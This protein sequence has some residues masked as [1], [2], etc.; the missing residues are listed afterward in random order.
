MQKIGYVRISSGTQNKAT[1]IEELKR[2][3]VVEIR[4]E[5]ITG[6]AKNKTVL[7][8]L[9]DE[10]QYGD[11]I[12]V[13]RLD[14]LGRN[15]SQLLLLVEQLADKGV[16]LIILDMHIDTGTRTGKLFLTIMAGISEME[17][18][19][20]KEKQRAGVELAKQSGKYKG[21]MKRYTDNNPRL[22][23]ALK[24]YTEGQKTVKE[25]AN[26]LSIGEATIYRELK[27]RAIVRQTTKRM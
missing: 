20:I 13:T 1:Q 4:E 3:G 8:T 17:R 2:N 12:V 24:W 19:L 5:T 23:Q 11:S 26:I 9:I 15:A 21:R 7:E 14:R 6:V 22:V 25:I 16:N 27:S 10:L 18:E